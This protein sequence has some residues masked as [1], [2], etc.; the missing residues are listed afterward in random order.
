MK[1]LLLPIMV[2]LLASVLSACGGPSPTEVT[3]SFMTA[4]KAADTDAISQLYAGEIDDIDFQ[5]GVSADSEDNSDPLT[6][7]LDEK[8][9]AFEYTVSNEIIDGDM[10][11]VDIAIKSYPLGEIFGEAVSEYISEAMTLAFSGASEEEINALLENIVME[12]LGEAA[13]DYESTVTLSLT[14]S[15]EGWIVDD[16]SEDSE[17][18]DALTGGMM[19][20]ASEMESTFDFGDM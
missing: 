9:L 7:D 6:K 15:D 12:K 20:F 14:N 18:M 10:A 8:F 17:F 11:T 16:I 5:D 4:I 1:K 2:L 13:M 19:S 3:N